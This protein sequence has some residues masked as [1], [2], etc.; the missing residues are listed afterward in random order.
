MSMICML[1]EVDAQQIE[2]LSANPESIQ[3]FLEEETEEVELEKAWHGLH[4]LLTGSAWEGDEP[5]CYLANGGTEI[6]EDLGYGPAR[7]LSPAQ[8]AAWNDALLTITTNEL[9]QRFDPAAL[10]Q[11]QIYPSIWDEGD[12]AF[13]W[14]SEYLEILRSFLAQAKSAHKGAL[15]YLT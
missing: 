2:A 10:E 1:R 5:L 8:V 12:E 9:R 11:A 4:Y 7:A 6:G 13:D 14:L 15:V 3:D